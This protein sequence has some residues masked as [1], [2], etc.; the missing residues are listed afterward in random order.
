M[1]VR[2]KTLRVEELMKILKG[3]Q[4]TVANKQEKKKA[5][6]NKRRLDILKGKPEKSDTR[7]PVSHKH[8]EPK[9]KKSKPVVNAVVDTATSNQCKRPSTEEA[10]ATSDN[11]S[12][13]R[14]KANKEPTMDDTVIPVAYHINGGGDSDDEPE[15]YNDSDNYKVCQDTGL[16]TKRVR[17]MGR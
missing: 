6:K 4:I 2:K 15:H 9:L 13:K 1:E 5:E 14:R 11:T 7:K 16:D 10:S 8:S 17:T 12:K 3:L